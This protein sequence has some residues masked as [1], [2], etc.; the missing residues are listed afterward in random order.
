MEKQLLLLR[1]MNMLQGSAK[2]KLNCS[3]KANYFSLE[4]EK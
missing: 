2:E 4:K 3:K 1:M